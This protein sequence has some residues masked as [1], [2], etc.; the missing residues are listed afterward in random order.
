MTR[1]PAEP[2]NFWR[3]GQDDLGCHRPACGAVLR[4]QPEPL[5]RAVGH[6]FA[7][8]AIASGPPCTP[9]AS[10][11]DSCPRRGATPA[12]A[13]YG[14]TNVVARTTA[15]AD[16]LAADE[17]IEG[18]RRLEEKVRR[19]SAA[20]GRRPGDHRLSDRVR[21]ARAAMLGR[22]TRRSRGRALG[23]TQSQ[24]PECP[25]STERPGRRLSHVTAGRRT[26]LPPTGGV[27]S[28]FAAGALRPGHPP[29]S[30]CGGRTLRT[31]RGRRA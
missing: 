18:R 11:S 22:T 20:T 16:E 31:V 12:P 23:L 6:H 1:P 13:G 8:P 10:P 26:G 25:L 14:I 17:L 19:L 7:R 15:T 2:R 9:P 27:A 24:R 4:D 21:P 30:S 29:P 5:L 28:W 3:R